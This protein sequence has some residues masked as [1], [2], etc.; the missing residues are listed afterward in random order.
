MDTRFSDEPFL[1]GLVSGKGF[2]LFADPI[3]VFEVVSTKAVC[4]N[5]P[6]EAIA[7][8]CG[9]E[10]GPLNY[11][12]QWFSKSI[13]NIDWTTSEESAQGYGVARHE[14]SLAHRLY[15]V[16]LTKHSDGQTGSYIIGVFR[17][18]SCRAETER[19][20]KEF[21]STVSHE[22][23][24]PL[25][26]IKGAM[27]L[28]LSGAAGAVP[29][30]A[31]Q[32]ISIAQRNADR[33]ILIIND[34]LD[35]D[36]IAEGAMV[37]D[38]ANTNLAA[39]AGEAVEAVA[40]FK[41][42]FEVN[43]ELEVADGNAISFVDPNR[44]VQVLVN[45]LSNAIK[46]SPTRATVIVRVEM[47]E[48][49]NRVSV[50]DSGEGISQE[51]Q[52]KLFDR[53]VQAGTRHRAATGGTG[54]GLSIVKEILDKQDGKISIESALGAG[55]SVHITLPRVMDQIQMSQQESAQNAYSAC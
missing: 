50:I 13:S 10:C 45:L 22:L 3:I 55:T 31:H 47:L 39:L 35:L 26:A 42:R 53:F 17:D 4:L 37:F 41:E 2:D 8:E 16:S 19:A 33:L 38:N 5:R 34:M 21:V 29:D 28:I 49:C 30:K 12:E 54:L 36:K 23:R 7:R 27:G 24:S 25:T 52:T 44:M 51:D 15:D 46:F 48:T 9:D 43:V 32:M 11:F 14:V 20:K 6:A 1:R 40:G 18:I